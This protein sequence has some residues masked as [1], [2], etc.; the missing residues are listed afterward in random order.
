MAVAGYADLTTLSKTT[1]EVIDNYSF[2]SEVVRL[3]NY[4]N[5]NNFMVITRDEEWHYLDADRKSDLVTGKFTNQT[6]NNIKT[7][8]SR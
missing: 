7:F 5:T 8:G 2:G 4:V 6:S 3:G 1:G